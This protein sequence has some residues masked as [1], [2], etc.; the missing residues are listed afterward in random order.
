MDPV[1]FKTP[2]MIDKDMFRKR[3][4]EIIFCPCTRPGKDNET[5]CAR[6]IH[7]PVPY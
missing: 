1:E 3:A 2:N 6:Q 5:K 7:I 4:D